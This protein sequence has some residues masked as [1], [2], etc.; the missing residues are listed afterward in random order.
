[1]FG[2]VFVDPT[3]RTWRRGWLVAPEAALSCVAGPADLTLSQC[4]LT[5]DMH[6]SHVDVVWHQFYN[7]VYMYTC[8]CSLQATGYRFWLC[9]M[10]D[11]RYIVY[12]V[13]VLYL[14]MYDLPDCLTVPWPMTD[15]DCGGGMQ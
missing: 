5:G 4:Q 12:Y 9:E 14:A 15:Y 6:A 10:R 2:V 1:M 8:R 7:A 13:H 3:P 11:E